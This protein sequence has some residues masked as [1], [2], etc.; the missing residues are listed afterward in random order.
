MRFKILCISLIVIIFSF[1]SI[2]FSEFKFK[3]PEHYK[4]DQERDKGYEEFINYCVKAHP[5]WTIED[6]TN[7]RM[8][9][10]IKNKCTK[11]L[12]NIQRSVKE[13]ANTNN[14]TNCLKPETVI[15]SGKLERR[16]FPGAPNFE[17]IKKGDKPETGF[18]LSLKNPVCFEGDDMIG[19]TQNISL[20]QLVLN[21]EGYNNLRPYLGKNV[22]LKGGLFGGSSGHH[23]TPILMENVSLIKN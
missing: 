21:E 3:C 9:L 4:T 2:C 15:L 10:L 14:P 17:S 16:T 22:K 19:R 13:E 12:E 20:V 8:E 23:H 5:N 18:Y 7:Y 6:L 1:P 11:T